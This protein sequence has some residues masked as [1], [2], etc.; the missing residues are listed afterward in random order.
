MAAAPKTHFTIPIQPIGKNP[1][2]S[3]TC[4]EPHPK[5][6]LLTISSPPDNRLTIHSCQALLDALDLLEFS[7][8][9]CPSKDGVVVTTSAIPKFYSNGL[10]LELAMSNA[11]FMPHSL[12]KLFA[13]FLTFPMPTVALLNGHAFAAGI[14]L[15]MHHDY[16]VMNSQK[17]FVCINEL[18]FG[19][20]LKPAMS[21]IFRIKTVPTVYRRIVLEA[22]RF[23]GKEALE[24]GI[25]DALGGF[26]EVVRLVEERKLREKGRS[27]IY[28]VMK[29]EMYRETLE[30]YLS[31]EGH[32]REE[33]RAVKEQG[34]K[35][36]LRR[37]R[38]EERVKEL[39]GGGGGGKLGAKL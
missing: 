36:D 7:P 25:V 9:I 26:E 2:G 6:Y 18:D 30:G 5:I 13:R 29:A 27:G 16:R 32:F 23:G 1:G 24:S 10:D 17:G 20:P 22:H 28:G 38:G 33:E 4:T 15:A 31:V 14:M 19:V 11:D 37:E 12:Y 39:V 35:E 34:E 3:L 8:T 21:A